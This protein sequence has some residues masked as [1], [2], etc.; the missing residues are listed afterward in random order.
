M[1]KKLLFRGGVLICII[2]LLATAF[3]VYQSKEKVQEKTI[4]EQREQYADFLKKSPY[5]ETLT[6]DKKKRKAHGLPPNKYYEQMWELTINPAT[7]RLDDGKITGLRQ[8][9]LQGRLTRRIPGEEGNAWEERGPNN[10][11]GRTRVVFFD[12]ND[13]T[14]NTVYAGGVSGGLWKNSDISNPNS[15]WARIINIPGNLS[16]TSITVDPRDSKVWYVGT[17]EQYTAGDVVGNGVYKTING[18]TTWTAMTIPPAG[19]GPFYF[20]ETNLFLSG[21]YYVNDVLAWDNGTF[22]EL[23][24]AVGAHVYGDASGPRNWLGLQSAGLYRS[25]DN[26]TTWNRTE[27]AN[28]AYAASGITFYIIPNDL[29]VGADN[30]LWMGTINSAFGVG[31]GRVYQSTDGVTWTGTGLPDSNRVEIE[32]SASSPGKLYA[33]TQGVSVGPVHIYET[34]DKFTTINELSLPNDDDPGISASDF[35]RGQAFYDLVI[36]ADP[37][38]DEILYVGG[39]DMFKTVNGGDDWSQ[40]TH[41]YGGFGHQ[42]MHADQHAISFAN[43]SSNKMMFGNDGGVAYTDNG[44]DVISVRNNNY[45]V[46]QFVKA[47]IGPDGVGDTKGIF[48]AG[49][50]DNGT[51]AFRNTVPGINSSE[52]L[53]DGD[54]FYTFVDKDGEYLIS[55]YVYNVIYRFDLPWDGQGRLEG[56]ATI[57]SSDFTGDFVNQMDYDSK[58]NR[59]L[60]NNTSNTG[61]AI[62]SIN[63]ETTA[64]GSITSSALDAKP[65]AFRASPFDDDVWYVGMAN[66]G[67][68]E[69]TEVTDSTAVF[70]ALSTPFVG[71]VSSVRLGETSNDIMVTIHNYGVESV[72]YSNNGGSV[73]F[74]KEGDLPDIPVRDI[75]QNPLDVNEVMLATQLGVWATSD[76]YSDNPTWTQSQN[77]MSDVSVTAFDYWAVNGDDTEHKIIAST[78]GRGVFTSSFNNI[79]VSPTKGY[80]FEKGLE[81][82]KMGKYAKRVKT[83][84]AVDG[85]YAIRVKKKS[86]MRSAWLDFSDFENVTISIKLKQNKV[87]YPKYSRVYVEYRTTANKTWKVIKSKKLRESLTEINA[88]VKNPK[89]K[90]QFRIRI[91][92]AEKKGNVYFDMI[93]IEGKEVL[94]NPLPDLVPEI[95]IFPNPT[96]AQLN[97]TNIKKDADFNIFNQSGT[98]VLSGRLK[99]EGAT[100]DVSGLAKGMY[101]LK[102]DGED[103]GN[104]KMFVKK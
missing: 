87:K 32:P 74:G 27:T 91:N 29:E 15:A 25:I 54:G 55:T 18:G 61:Y 28:M 86:N 92:L 13:S 99:K 59:L 60:T 6:W 98:P 50:Q 67:V 21:L 52:E 62:K 57:L 101:I 96:V 73:W 90:G 35:T 12:P 81:G 103:K 53:S 66:G 88:T 4:A 83:I 43:N 17:G 45:N 16:V 49:A 89:E 30:S 7:G 71:S 14:N 78:Y 64:S 63:V 36:E 11:G 84:H 102:I 48:T 75:L 58:A 65:T 94:D 23:Y 37:A 41:W 22:T 85:S 42:Y 33:L 97:I 77:G 76:F 46:T 93:E 95:V 68:L 69:L 56:A 72:W 9:L 5:K 80:S 2:A 70:R 44:G 10:V 31:G 34:T 82:W 8:Q 40:L 1:I 104:A 3:I 51:Q 39:I 24:V 100:I 38:N 20:G 47:G 19:P 79:T 26:G